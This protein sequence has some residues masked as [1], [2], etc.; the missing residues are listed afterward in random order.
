MDIVVSLAGGPHSQADNL[1]SVQEPREHDF[2]IEVY[3]PNTHAQAKLIPLPFLGFHGGK[4]T[5]DE[6][7][8]KLRTM[9]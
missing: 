1:L 7:A 3:P 5:T 8:E 2:T 9:R 6:S 4:E